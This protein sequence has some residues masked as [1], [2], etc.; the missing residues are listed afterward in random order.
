MTDSDYSCDSEDPSCEIY[1]VS[2]AAERDCIIFLMYGGGPSGGYLLSRENNVAEWHQDW[3]TRKGVS[4]VTGSLWMHPD[5]EYADNA[6]LSTEPPCEGAIQ[7]DF[8]TMMEC[9][10]DCEEQRIE[11]LEQ[12]SDDDEQQG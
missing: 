8:D 5:S 7:Y 9:H 2:Y 3:D 6:I 1:N 11:L 10:P 4:P 12:S